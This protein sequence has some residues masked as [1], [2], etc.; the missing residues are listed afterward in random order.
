MGGYCY[1]LCHCFG[2]DA[3]KTFSGALTDVIALVAEKQSVLGTYHEQ[4]KRCFEK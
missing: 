3:S 4:W 1:E 2:G